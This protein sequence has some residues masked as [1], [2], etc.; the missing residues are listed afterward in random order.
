[1]IRYFCD[2]CGKETARNYVDT[3]LRGERRI[4]GSPSGVAPRVIFEVILGAQDAKYDKTW[5]HGTMCRHCL[6]A[7]LNTLAI[8]LDRNNYD[9]T[10]DKDPV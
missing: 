7:L 6:S 4:G 2:C 9:E 1:M 3:R 10:M 5:N 8:D